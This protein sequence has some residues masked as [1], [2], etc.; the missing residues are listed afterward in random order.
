MEPQS[1]RLFQLLSSVCRT[2]WAAA[3]S[4]WTGSHYQPLPL[5][6]QSPLWEH[7]T[8]TLTLYR[9]INWWLILFIWC[10]ECLIL[11]KYTAIFIVIDDSTD[12]LYHIVKKIHV[13][14]CFGSN[15]CILL[16]LKDNLFWKLLYSDLTWSVSTF[17]RVYFSSSIPLCFLNTI[18]HIIQISETLHSQ[19]IMNYFQKQN[20]RINNFIKYSNETK[21]AN[22][23][24]WKCFHCFTVMVNLSWVMA[25][26]G[27]SPWSRVLYSMR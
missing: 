20:K 2:G 11:L 3:L 23:Q 8:H 6:T 14:S 4:M 27:Y 26:R 9:C 17:W 13:L 12:N 19:G 18:N 10:C 1:Q 25:S 7:T 15:S 16:S 5:R 24:M 22:L 21:R